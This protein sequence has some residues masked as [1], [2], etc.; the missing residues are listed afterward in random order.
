MKTVALDPE[1][2]VTFGSEQPGLSGH[3]ARLPQLSRDLNRPEVAITRG[4]ADS[5]SLRLAN[6]RDDIHA[7]YRPEGK[8]ARAVIE[9]VEQARVDAL[10][11]Q[12]QRR[13]RSNR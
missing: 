3:R 12:A 4:L 13:L 11:R 6:H 1:L 9:A 7:R 8:T 10:S 2:Q 5:M